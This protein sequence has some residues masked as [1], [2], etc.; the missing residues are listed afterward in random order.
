MD[1]LPG[2]GRVDVFAIRDRLIG[3]Y[4]EFVQ[5]FISIQDQRI[6]RHVDETSQ[7][8]G[9]WPEP[10]V[11][12]YRSFAPGESLDALIAR[13]CCTPNAPNIFRVKSKDNPHGTELPFHK[14]QTEAI[15]VATLEKATS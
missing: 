10:L 13:A 15:R 5:S 1:G 6:S 8:R 14:H 2:G 11:Q 12:R 4:A 7:E 9:P 3:D